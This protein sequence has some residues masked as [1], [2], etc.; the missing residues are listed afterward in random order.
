[1][2]AASFVALETKIIALLKAVSLLTTTSFGETLDTTTRWGKVI[3][4]F[5]ESWRSLNNL[6]SGY[7]RLADV[8]DMV[9]DLTTA[10][11]AENIT[12]EDK[13]RFVTL[14]FLSIAESST[15]LD[16]ICIE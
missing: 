15:R 9:A 16:V 14:T 8:A 5:K 11:E 2:T 10:L 1:M 4:K 13:D 3:N 12:I 7:E 6:C